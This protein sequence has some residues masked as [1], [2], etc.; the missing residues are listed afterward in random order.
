MG[1]SDRLAAVESSVSIR[2]AAILGVL[3]LVVS[4]LVV[5]LGVGSIALPGSIEYGPLGGADPGPAYPTVV[6]VTGNETVTV[7]YATGP[8]ETEQFVVED[9]DPRLSDDEN[10]WA[11]V[12][13]SE[14]PPA[15]EDVAGDPDAGVV[16][17]GE[18]SLV[19]ELS[20][21]TRDAGDSTVTVVVPAGRDVDP[22]RKAYF[23]AE[24]VS[25]YSFGPSGTDVTL[26]AAPD[27]LPHRGL[28]YSD[29]TGYVTV[30]WFWD[31]SVGSVWIHEYV[32]ARQEF[33]T[34]CEMSWFREA[35]A[36]YLAFRIMQE[37]HPE[38]TD[39]DVRSRLDSLPEHREASLA[40]CSSWN[41]ESVDYTRGVRLLYAVD[42]EIRAGSDG[43]HTLFDVF[44]A[45]NERDEPVTVEEFRRLVEQHSG[46]DEAWIET[47]I[48]ET[49][50]MDCYREY[51]G[52]FPEEWECSP[53][54]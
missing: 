30:E 8:D 20:A 46:T 44:R 6:D 39:E 18:L 51:E 4:I 52:T 43:E 26:V 53:D 54:G 9:V 35:S 42:A 48:T 24:Y 29:D 10:G 36:E 50:E 33:T 22:E 14:L 28:M 15:L 41:D 34:E 40:N 16:T 27:A 23:L 17:V 1:S 49:G 32:H 5:S 47:A 45:M 7:E 37:Q 2:R 13:R 3:L 19:G 25:P 21:A 12:A 38:V 31:G 11:F